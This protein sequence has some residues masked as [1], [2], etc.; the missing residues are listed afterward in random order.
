MME[1]VSEPAFIAVD[2]GQVVLIPAPKGPPSQHPTAPAIPALRDRD[3]ASL[4]AVLCL[5][6]E[7][8]HSEGRMLG[9]LLTHDYSTKEELGAAASHDDQPIATGTIGVFV[10]A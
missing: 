2:R 3:E 8:K 7:L 6:F 9:R 5:L 10:S 4:A 1:K